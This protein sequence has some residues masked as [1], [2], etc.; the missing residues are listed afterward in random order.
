[1][2]DQFDECEPQYLIK[3]ET[4]WLEVEKYKADVSKF[5]TEK[6][7]EIGNKLIDSYK[8]YA[9]SGRRMI[10]TAVFVFIALI[11]V[12]M[13]ILTFFDKVNGET[14]AFVTGTIVGYIISILKQNL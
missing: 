9:T 5:Q 12:S 4:K 14:F 6:Y 1:M 10:T 2:D 11:F 7:L 8:E 3:D 13:A